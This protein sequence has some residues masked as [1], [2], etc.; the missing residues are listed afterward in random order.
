MLVALLEFS[1]IIETYYPGGVGNLQLGE[2]VP[3]DLKGFDRMCPWFI[4]SFGKH[5]KH[6]CFIEN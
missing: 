1:D 6:T 4:V 3:D 2:E 5:G